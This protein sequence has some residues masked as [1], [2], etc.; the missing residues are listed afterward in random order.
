MKDNKKQLLGM[1]A[2]LGA[3]FIF[4]FSFVFSKM[5]LRV[6]HP[7]IILAVRFTVAFLVM[8]I[9]VLTRAVKINLRGKK[10]GKLLLMCIAQPLLYFVFE[11]YGL[12]LTSSALS[13]IVISLV[14]V[15]VI[16]MSTTFLGEKPTALQIICTIISIVGV[17]VISLISNDGGKNHIVG[18]VLLVLTVLSASAFNIL[19]RSESANFTPFE[20]TYFMFLVGFVGFNTIAAVALRG[21]YVSGLISAVCEWKFIVAILY[22]AVLS[23][24]FAFL[25]YNYS[26]TVIS[27]VR[28]SSFSNIIT[29]VS[30]LAGTIILKEDFSIAQLLLC[31][32]IIL[33]VWGVNFKQTN[34]NT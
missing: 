25:M 26:T 2:A 9:L 4:G 13:G 24:V 18:I 21:E 7:L 22:L 19:S 31:I 15:G 6:A 12:S 30:V 20:R 34:K 1:A 32:P 14:P 28:S 27:A 11:L 8:N 23:S 10:K 3:N 29:V 33:G 5:A 16:L 17:A